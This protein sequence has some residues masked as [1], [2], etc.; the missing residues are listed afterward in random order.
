MFNHFSPVS[1]IEIQERH[2]KP[3]IPRWPYVQLH[4]C[5]PATWKRAAI[6]QQPPICDIDT[7]PSLNVHFAAA[8][9]AVVVQHFVQMTISCLLVACPEISLEMPF[10]YATDAVTG[11]GKLRTYCRRVLW[12]ALLHVAINESDSASMSLVNVDCRKM[13]WRCPV[14]FEMFDSIANEA[15]ASPPVGN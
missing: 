12:H 15:A 3:R 1:L 2:C 5:S 11:R 4:T 10:F 13:R 9:A 7:I 14:R 6:W 8:A